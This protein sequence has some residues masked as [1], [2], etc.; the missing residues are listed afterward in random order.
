LTLWRLKSLLRKDAF[1]GT[2][3]ELKNSSPQQLHEHLLNL[4]ISKQ[5]QKQSQ[6]QTAGYQVGVLD[7]K[8][9]MFL[10]NVLPWMGSRFGDDKNK[11]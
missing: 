10:P 9:N 11:Q 4:L 1:H 6:K 2:I 5:K 7:R 8:I 3:D